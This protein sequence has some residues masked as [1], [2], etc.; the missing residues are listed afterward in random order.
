MKIKNFVIDLGLLA[1]SFY[2]TSCGPSQPELS[3]GTTQ[4]A[5]NLAVTPTVAASTSTPTFTPVPPTA[6]PKPPTSTP[7]PTATPLPPTATFTPTPTK[8]PV[9]P[10]A[11]PSPTTTPT[12]TPLPPTA[13]VAATALPPPTSTSASVDPADAPLAIVWS[14]QM[15]YEGNVGDARW[16]QINMTYTNNSNDV[17]PWPDF[18]PLFFISSADDSQTFITSGNFYSKADG[19]A[20]GIVGLPPDIPAGTSADWTWYTSTRAAGE[21]CFGVAIQ[22]QG[23]VYAAQYEPDGRLLKTG[24]MPPK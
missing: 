10:T 2:L 24:I 8:T 4:A 22:F 7:T 1:L 12:E 9:P 13:T 21:T 19:W 6:T 3:A 16:C 23:W 5:V 15:T 20:N 11:T 14:E 17:Y 18:R